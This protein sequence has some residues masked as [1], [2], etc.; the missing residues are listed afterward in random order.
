MSIPKLIYAC[1]VATFSLSVAHAQ[2]RIAEVL[3]GTPDLRAAAMGHSTLGNTR[4]MH[5]YTNPASM[6]GNGQRL[7]LDW[8]GE[9]FPD[10]EVGRMRQHNVSLGYR[11]TKSLAL[12]AGWR[13]LSG[14][15]L[16][17]TEARGGA[18]EI[19]PYG[20][21]WDLGCALAVAEGL[22]LYGT[23]TLL[24]EHL[25]TTAHGVAL[26]VGLSY[27]RRLDISPEMPT[28]L[29]VGLRL[30]DAGK[31]VQ[32][33]NTKLPYSLPTSVLLGGEWG[34]QLAKRHQVSYALSSRFFTTGQT[35]KECHIGTG[36]EYTYNHSLSARL[37]YRY[38]KQG[39][40]LLTFGLGYELN[41]RYRVNVVY[42]HAPAIYGVDRLMLGLGFSL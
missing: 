20:R 28:L 27:Q 42:N 11:V 38:A 29:T 17:T 15:T 40:D 5:L 13:Q 3:H 7:S 4:E 2:G 6:L 36:L 31:P 18:A 39:A 25:G 22:T 10:S 41:A 37:G 9:W 34:V 8:S 21:T 1:A 12:M 30:Q 32:F 16:P 33:D 14:L 35:D 23:A 19:K 26:G 24:T